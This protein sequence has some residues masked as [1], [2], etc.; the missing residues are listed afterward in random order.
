MKL[1]LTGKPK[2]GK[3]TLLGDLINSI[4]PKRGMVAV[5]VLK[6]GE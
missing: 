4:S 3:T 5:E 2:S 1:L 6:N